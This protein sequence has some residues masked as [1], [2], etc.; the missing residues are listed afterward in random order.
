MLKFILKRLLLLIPIIIGITFVVFFILYFSPGD[1][2]R[3]ILGDRASA[4]SLQQLRHEMGLDKS[5][6][7]QY[8]GYIFRAVQ[9]DFGRSYISSEPVLK[10]IL[11]RFPVTLK[12]TIFSTIISILLGVPIGIISA[13]RKYSLFDRGSMILVLVIISMPSFWLGLLLIL[14]FSLKLHWLPSGGYVN[15]TSL[16]LPAVCAGAGFSA[17]LARM[18]RQSLLEEMSKDYVSTAQAK[19]LTK[20]KAVLKH[21]LKNSMMPMITVVGMRFAALLGGSVLVENVFSLAGVGNLM[22]NAINQKDIPVVM[23]SVIMMA[24]VFCIANLFV[25]IIQVIINPRIRTEYI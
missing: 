20:D 16:I 15:L 22:L 14:L 11:E 8:G 2:A 17:I 9:G 7:E 23:A 21:A 18:T 13:I 10:T 4:Q 12:L 6:L 5:L 3:I 25:D 1:P 19:G 24:I